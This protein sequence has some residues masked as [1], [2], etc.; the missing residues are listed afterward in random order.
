MK[1]QRIIPF[2]PGYYWNGV[3]LE[4]TG[5]AIYPT[6]HID[7]TTGEIKYYVRPIGWD[8]GAYIRRNGIVDWIIKMEG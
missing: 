4:S 5:A 2:L 6:Q 8:C 3:T 7:K 1:E